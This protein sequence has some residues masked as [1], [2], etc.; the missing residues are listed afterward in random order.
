VNW[1]KELEK[2][3]A[4]LPKASDVHRLSVEEIEQLPARSP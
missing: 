1:F 4:P 3:T 2:I